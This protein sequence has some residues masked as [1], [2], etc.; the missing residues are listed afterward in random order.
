MR[1]AVVFVM[2]KVFKVFRTNSASMKWPFC[3][4]YSLT[5]PNIVQ[6]CRNSHQSTRVSTLA[7]KNIV[8]KNLNDSS[9]NKKE[10]HPNLALLVQLWPPVSPWRW[11]KSKKIG[12]IFSYWAIQIFQNQ[13]SISSLLSRKNTITISNIWAIFTR[14]Q[15]R[16][17]NQR[18]R[19]KIWQNFVNLLKH[20]PTFSSFAAIDKKGH[21]RKN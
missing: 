12:K 20:F 7:S 21:F 6:H 14:K 17:K 15:G 19:I 3:G 9:F 8:W 2:L 18:V 11:L 16:G 13:G 1:I 5:A 10:M 4:R